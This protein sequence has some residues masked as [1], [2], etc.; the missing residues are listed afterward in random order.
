MHFDADNLPIRRPSM[1]A[2]G[3]WRDIT[4]ND[5][6]DEAVATNGDALALAATQFDSGEIRSFT[7]SELNAM[8]NR[9]AVG[10][11]RLGV[12]PSDVVAV[13]LPNW[14]EFTVTHLACARIGAVTNPLMHI[15]RE[16][17]LE[18]MLNH[19]EAVVAVIPS[20]FRGHD[21][22]AM[23][24][25]IRSK[26]PSLEHIIAIGDDGP[27]GFEALLSGPAWENEPDAEAILTENRPN[28]D[29]VTQLI[30]TSG[31]TGEPKGVM[32]S[33]NTM[34][35]NILPYAERLNLDGDDVVLMASP[36][37]HQTGF[38][39]GLMMP[40]VLGCPSVI[41]DVWDAPTAISIVNTYGATF[42]MAST[43][44]LADLTDT[45]ASAGT[46]VPS[47]STFLCAGAPIPGPLVERAQANL[48]AAIVSAWGMS[49]NGATTT[50]MLDDDPSRA[51]ETDGCPLP[52]V[53]VRIADDD[54]NTLLTGEIGRLL[55]RGCSNFG[56]YLKR[57]HLN[58]TDADGWFDTGDLA[59]VDDKGY[60]RIT[61]RSKDVIIRG[62]E[63]IPVVE[64]EN[65]LYRHPSVAQ[66]AIVAYPDERLGERACAVIV[67]KPDTS[68]DFDGMIEFLTNERVAK[69]Y[70]PERLKVLDSMPTTPSGKIQKF[71]LRDMIVGA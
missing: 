25:D 10:L 71:K 1:V 59:R 58:A 28:A 61:G 43:P 51:I 23:Y 57:P 46:G 50:T 8:V 55:T 37:A 19:G 9:I 45:V 42:T 35:S 26:V 16:R 64:I 38:M 47:L 6:L 63:N 31:T 49:E 11:Y 18:F 21:F 39:Y 15:F 14:W 69:N 24:G 65:L 56:G 62:G 70:L 20:I 32:H 41:L 22:A 17:E 68:I 12:R 30:Y 29:D 52:G 5:S 44:F 3:H 67:A 2:A 48:G 54:G 33:A 7:Y 34:Y 27:S 4:I 60:I 13:Q 40:V 53:E 36:M 66:V